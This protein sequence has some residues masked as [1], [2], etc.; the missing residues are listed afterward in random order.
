MTKFSSNIKYYSFI[1]FPLLVAVTFGIVFKKF[2]ISIDDSK[3]D[4]L[5]SIAASLIG[6]LLTIIT[7][8]LAIP[9]DPERF[10]LLKNS[11]HYKI[12]MRNVILGL[13]LFLAT[14]FL[15]FFDIPSMWP[16]ICFFA[17]ISNSVIISY[18]TFSLIK[19]L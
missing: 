1:V 2:N 9:K 6:V 13:A 19:L 17:A 14:I 3:M 10:E 7:I 16:A 5:V 12:Y 8:L 11:L 18:Y 4:V 15:W